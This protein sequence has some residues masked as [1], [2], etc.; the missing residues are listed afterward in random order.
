MANFVARI[1][2]TVQAD[3]AVEDQASFFI[4]ERHMKESTFGA[5]NWDDMHDWFIDLY[6]NSS[7]WINPNA[8]NLVSDLIASVNLGLNPIHA[9]QLIVPIKSYDG[10]TGETETITFSIET[11]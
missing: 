6:S 8:D 7:Y 5:K 10:L 2:I 4:E 9:R 1:N 11:H 3:Y